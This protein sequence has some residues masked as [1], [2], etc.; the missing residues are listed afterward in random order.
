VVDGSSPGVF[1]ANARAW[2]VPGVRHVRPDRRFAAPNGKVA[3]VHTGLRLARHEHVV[4]ADDDVRY[5]TATLAAIQI[6]LATADLVWPQNHFVP[7][8]WHARWD[9]GRTLLNRC[10]GLDYPGTVGLR[11][12]F[13][14]EM[15][16]YRGDV[17]F[18]NLEL[19]R[20]V[21]AAGGREAVALDLFVARRPPTTRRFLTQRVRQAYDSLAS[22]L[23]L[24]LELAAAPFVLWSVARRRY[25]R[26]LGAA[27]F[28][29]AVAE[30]GRRRA[31]GRAVFPRTSSLWAPAWVL[32]RGVCVWPAVASR[33]RGGIRY[34]GVRIRRA[35]TSGRRRSA[36]IGRG[37]DGLLGR[38]PLD[39]EDVGVGRRQPRPL[40]LV[41]AGVRR[42]LAGVRILDRFPVLVHGAGVVGQVDHHADPA[43]GASE[44]IVRHGTP[45][46]TDRPE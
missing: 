3:G 7:A 41:T 5:T 24:S 15:G 43:P 44:L 25:R 35:A 2:D 27:V 1:A 14:E 28:S 46:P 13:F 29:V 23:R 39:V 19:L 32:E 11:R 4:V 22:P 12:S 17:L 42:Q 26:L 36:G 21:R 30:L 37:L 9:T 10:A 34:R 38:A 8:P 6:R 16:G 20:T 31:G 33:L 18:E 45:I 40:D